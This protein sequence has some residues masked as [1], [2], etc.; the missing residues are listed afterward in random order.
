[1]KRP[2]AGKNVEK[3]ALSYAADRA[4]KQCKHFGEECSRCLLEST[5]FYHLIQTFPFWI[6]TPKIGSICPHRFYFFVCVHVTQCTST[7]IITVFV[8]DFKW[9]QPKCPC[10]GEQID[11]LSHSHITE[12][13]LVTKMNEVLMHAR[14][15][16]T[17]K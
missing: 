8:T 3:H 5:Y 12:C 15:R 2:S 6:F 10:P 17:L 16:I 7:F 13:W 4:E 11:K 1:M 14:T 9:K